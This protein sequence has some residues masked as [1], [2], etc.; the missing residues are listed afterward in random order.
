MT[1]QEQHIH[2][3]ALFLANMLPRNERGMYPRIEFALNFHAISGFTWF[4]IDKANDYAK[5][6]YD[7]FYPLLKMLHKASEKHYEE[8]MEK[9]EV[10][11]VFKF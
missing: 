10:P 11:S 3:T 7:F 1:K 2:Q 9:L 6:H 8:L 5:S 4:I